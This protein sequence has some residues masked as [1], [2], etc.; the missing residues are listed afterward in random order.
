[1]SCEVILDVLYR[2][3]T[4]VCVLLLQQNKDTTA[5]RLEPVATVEQKF[6]QVNIRLFS[7]L[8]I[9]LNGVS[10]ECLVF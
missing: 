5:I 9:L 7:Q 4:T 2:G 3:N 1:M 10:P 8:I 6:E